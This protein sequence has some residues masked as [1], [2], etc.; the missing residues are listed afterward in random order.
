MHKCIFIMKKRGQITLFIII[1]LLILISLFLLLY[2]ENK[3]NESLD[4]TENA[5]IKP[6]K[7]Y[8]DSSINKVVER[9]IYLICMQGGYYDVPNPVDYSFI[10]IPYYFYLGEQ[11]IPERETIENEFSKYLKEELPNYIDNLDAFE[12]LGYEFEIG[13]M[14][15]DSSFGETANIKINYPIT[16][17]KE[18]TSTKIEEF[19][20]NKNFDFDKIY[21]AILEFASEHQKNPDFV[22]IGYLSSS[23]YHN[24]FTYKL[25]YSSNNTVVYSFVFNGALEEG[26]D[27][28]FNFAARYEWS[29]LDDI[30]MEVENE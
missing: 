18:D 23:A 22:P 16:I 17:K 9:G 24:D 1:G 26:Q 8:L 27:L 4:K 29:E 13:N 12:D 3:K 30:N 15:I 21:S 2:I 20:Y 14:Q 19:Y 11:S 25:S 28:L 7:I 10:K 6:I 5:D